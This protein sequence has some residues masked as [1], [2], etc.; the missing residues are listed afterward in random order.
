MTV[1]L[2]LRPELEASLRAEAARSG[3]ALSDYI[4]LQLEIIRP[5]P[6][7]LTP[8]EK[9]AILTEDLDKLPRAPLLSD[10]AI[11]RE[12]IYGDHG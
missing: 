1:I 9:I 4:A 6:R 2:D 11:S 3:I 5:A 10:E 8:A 7:E 12:S